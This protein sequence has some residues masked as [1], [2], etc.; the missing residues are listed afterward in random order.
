MRGTQARLLRR[1]AKTWPPELRRKAYRRLKRN[2]QALN[3]HQ[4]RHAA[5]GIEQ[6]IIELARFIQERTETSAQEGN[7]S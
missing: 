3:K 7:K 6:A 4:R 5:A 1:Y 2:W